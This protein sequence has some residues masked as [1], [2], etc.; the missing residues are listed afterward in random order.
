MPNGSIFGKFQPKVVPTGRTF[1]LPW[2][3]VIETLWPLQIVCDI[4]WTKGFGF[5]VT[6]IV[7]GIPLQVPVK[8]DGVTV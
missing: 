5:T 8:F 7:N 4:G 6:L 3:G 1:P 2:V